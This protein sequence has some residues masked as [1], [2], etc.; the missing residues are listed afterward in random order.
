MVAN[1]D[2][3]PDFRSRILILFENRNKR[4][5]RL[6]AA[7]LE[8]IDLGREVGLGLLPVL[9]G[10]WNCDRPVPEFGATSQRSEV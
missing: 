8:K 4:P 2:G 6:P 3:F 5:E 10:V 1:Y 7:L 9:L